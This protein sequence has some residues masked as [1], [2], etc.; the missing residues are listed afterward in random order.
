MYFE[1]DSGTFEQAVERHKELVEEWK[2]DWGSEELSNYH[3]IDF[4]SGET[5]R[6]TPTV[7]VLD[8]HKIETTFQL[9]VKIS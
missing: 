1:E 8:E 5:V 7:P 9:T 6:N 4:D 2:R 3:D